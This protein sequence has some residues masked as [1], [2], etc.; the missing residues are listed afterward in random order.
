MIDREQLCQHAAAISAG[1]PEALVA[2]HLGHEPPQQRGGVP[3]R[4]MRGGLCSGPVNANPGSDG[5]TRVAMCC[6]AVAEVEFVGAKQG[7]LDWHAI[8]RALRSVA[9]RRAALDA[10]EARWLREA[11]A[12]QIWR[13]LG[14]VSVLDYLE[15]VLGY[16]P[17]TAQ[18][19]LRV[20]RALG[21]LPRLTAALASGELAFS[22]VREL[23]RV[24]TPA[25][26]GAWVSRAR[27]SNLRQIEDLVAHRKPGDTACP[28]CAGRELA[29]P[30]VM[31][32]RHALLAWVVALLLAPVVLPIGAWFML[33]LLPVTVLLA[34]IAL[35]F[36]I[37]ALPTL[38]VSA[39]P[40]ESTGL[41]RRP[42]S[43]EV[44]SAT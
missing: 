34:P 23:T 18:D 41:P 7:A 40:R 30:W 5:T 20:A 16:A 6:E 33:L 28:S 32:T 42:A 4:L 22:V 21:A 26:E 19:L 8:D 9:G 15:R 31:K 2:E 43:N 24:A 10:G 44:L 38:I 37:A 1:D 25:T 12:L 29:S 17:R 36:G 39:Q 3:V 27:G 13:P 11:E 14:M 35:L